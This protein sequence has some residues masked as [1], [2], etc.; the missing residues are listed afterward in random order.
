MT[1]ISSESSLA[2]EPLRL[3]DIT[4]G[5][6]SARRAGNISP[7]EGTGEYVQVSADGARIEKYSFL[8]GE[9]TAVLFDKSLPEASAIKDF[10]DYIISPDGETLLIGCDAKPI[11][12]RSF[13]ATYYIYKVKDHSIRPLS[14]NGEVRVPV[15]SP[16]SRRI[17]FVRDNNI[18]LTDGTSE[19]QITT[20]GE[21][22]SIINGVPD[23]V[24]EEEFGFNTAMAWT[25]DSRHLCW[26]RY[27][28]QAVETYSLQLFDAGQSL[29]PYHYSYKYPK[30]GCRNSDV[31]AWSYDTATGKTARLDIP[32]DA[33]GY[34]PRILTIP[35]STSVMVYTMNRHQDLLRLFR[36]DAATGKVQKLIE[37]QSDKYV[38]EEA[39][40]GITIMPGHILLPSDRTGYMHL[41]LYDMQGRLL[42]QV[43]KGEYDV[44]SVYGYDSA[45]GK[46]YFQAAL[47]N[48]W[49]R[50]V[51][52]ADKR[53]KQQVIGTQ[54][55]WHDAVFSGDYKYMVHEWSDRNTP[56]RSEVC[57][58]DGKSVRQIEDNKELRDKLAQC[59]LAT[60]EFF[61]FT[62]S[63]GVRLNG[64]MMKPAD[65]DAAK[66]YPVVMHQ[67][68]GPGSQKVVDSW[69]IGSM[70]QGGMYDSYLVQHGFIVVT[71]DG[72]GTGGRGSEFE[73]A[74]YLR[75]GELEAR[76][77]V[78]TAVY[79]AG[80]PYVDKD[81]IGLWG[82][83][84]GGF[85]TLM[86]MSE[87]RPVFR[88]GV[89]IA[90]PTDWRFYDT[91]YTER[92][93]RTPEENA[94]GY[95]INPIKR[96]EKLHGKLLICHG[97]ADDNVHPQN[98]FEYSMAL[99]VADKDFREMVYT[100]KNH[101]IYGGNTRNHLLRQVAQFF[102][103]ELGGK[104]VTE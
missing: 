49:S 74:V 47:P 56:Y 1:L 98:T 35:S 48:A 10:D 19:Q 33:D 83:S 40:E 75:M 52:V 29:Y 67:Y 4:S 39:M 87:G 72:R 66:K 73:K 51:V 100:N 79:L 18:Y 13:T 97:L 96:A 89:A 28:E 80:L 9:L 62:T 86:S 20:D 41:Y 71:V 95:D 104:P 64:C 94:A 85:C 81:R 31:S 59:D 26:L 92:Y 23:W 68:S 55:G 43:D 60:K 30:A 93:M 15:F 58:S 38:K 8:T 2:S 88:A 54:G 36:A 14:A 57:R 16:D 90:P 91:V 102:V 25:G 82:W 5:T 22:N 63:E 6:Y 76:D 65:F 45:S 12:R 44:T 24:N 50:S 46:T 7:L 69:S 101:G 21:L 70:G 84:F 27:D 99:V 37:E 32:C 3:K 61:S 42:R 77:Q 17:A 78:E 103:D 34:M 11:Y 53:G